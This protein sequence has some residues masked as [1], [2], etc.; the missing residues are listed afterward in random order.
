MDV[1][2]AGK[3]FLLVPGESEVAGTDGPLYTYSV[4][5]Q[6]GLGL[7]PLRCAR[8]IERTLADERGWTRGAVR[9]KRVEGNSGTTVLLASPEVTDAVCAPLRTQGE[10]SCCRDRYVVLNVKRW[11][12][13]V[14][15]W[16]G[17][18]TSYRQ[19]LINHE[20]GHRIGKGHSFCPGADQRAPVMQQQTYGLQGCRANSWPLDRELPR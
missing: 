6:R 2:F 4:Y 3:P 19:M 7:K 9:F 5:V 20:F 16:T 1:T 13:A 11:R 10:V 15:H 14:P 12:N 17:D 18:L 8:R